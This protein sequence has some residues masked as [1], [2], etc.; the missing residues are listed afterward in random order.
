MF[1]TPPLTQ[2]VNLVLGAKD[3]RTFCSLYFIVLFN[4]T[5][6]CQSAM[7]AEEGKVQQPRCRSLAILK[8]YDALKEGT[9][10]NYLSPT[11]DSLEK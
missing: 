1:L 8:A 9:R 7:I 3:Q 6:P 2:H 11:P 10:D 4:T 5:Q